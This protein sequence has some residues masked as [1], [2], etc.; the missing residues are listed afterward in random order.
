[1]A[2]DI[3]DRITRL[4]GRVTIHAPGGQTY[5]VEC[6]RDV[7]AWLSQTVIPVDRDLLLEARTYLAREWS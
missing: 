1:M 4:N 3:S 5:G 6:L 2:L 7:D